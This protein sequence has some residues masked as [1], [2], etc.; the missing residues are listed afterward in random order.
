[1]LH[2][3]CHFGQSEVAEMLL[4]AGAD[5]HAKEAFGREPLDVAAERNLYAEMLAVFEATEGP[6]KQLR[7]G[8][9]ASSG[10]N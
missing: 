10:T 8:S 4:R 3:A 2:W 9:L 1:M 5:P 6:Q 7:E